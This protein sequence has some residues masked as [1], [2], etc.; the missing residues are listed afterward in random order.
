MNAVLSIQPWQLNNSQAPAQRLRLA[1][2]WLAAPE[3]Q[4]EM[5]WRSTIGEITR[6][7]IRQLNPSSQFPSE[8][9]KLRDRLNEYLG[10]GLE[11]PGVVQV[12]IAT[13]LFSPPGL[14][15][16]QGPERY[17]PSWLLNDCINIYNNSE[18]A[19]PELLNS[20]RHG[21]QAS[22]D[23]NSPSAPDFGKFPAGLNELN[24]NRLQLNRMLGLAN[25]YYIDPEDQEIRVELENLR[26]QFSQAILNCEE[27]Q[28]QSLWEG[29]L[30]DRYWAIVRSGIQK[31]ALNSQ[32][33]TIK[34]QV[35]HKLTPSLGGGFGQ[36]GSTNAMLVAMLYFE[37]GTMKV[38]G[39]EEKLPAWLLG[40]YKEIF[41][42]PLEATS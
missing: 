14:F 3:D 7:F 39:A 29:D 16:I 38:D 9:I 13:F 19:E 22:Q 23:L 8:E 42:K 15:S 2:L 5:L 26:Q 6:S 31:E 11:Q 33:Q 25:L 36:P 40:G 24:N 37:P 41:A 18:Q 20:P 12:M 34:D 4:L 27:A 28:L 17:F 35:S 30:G 1:Q 10:Q 21:V 32:D